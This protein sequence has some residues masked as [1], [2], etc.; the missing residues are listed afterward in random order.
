M[1]SRQAEP[2]VPVR[3]TQAQRKA[4]AEVAPELA[5]RLKLG[6]GTSGP[7]PSPGRS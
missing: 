5:G 7:S 2:K 6:S 3:L 1:P 4:V